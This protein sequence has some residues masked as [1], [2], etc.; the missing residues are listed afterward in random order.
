MK[1]IENFDISV[2]KEE[3]ILMLGGDLNNAERALKIIDAN[4]DAYNEALEL[5]KPRAIYDVIEI[6][7]IEGNRLY[8]DSE[9]FFESKLI[10]RLMSGTKYLAICV[11]T[12]GIDLENKVEEYMK[13][14]QHVK[15]LIMDG[16]GTVVLEKAGLQIREILKEEATMRNLDFSA[17]LSPGQ[18]G[19]DVS[20]QRKIFKRLDASRIGVSLR[21]S[22]LMIPRKS[23]S[24]AMGIG[25]GVKHDKRSCDFCHLKN[26][27]PSRMLYDY[28]DQKNK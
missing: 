3:L 19:W 16:V 14:G 18:V 21:P 23:L 11:I 13:Q 10:P 2:D 28:Q 12:V 27:C 17:A 4:L 6:D 26:S 22:S 20:D 24:L 1:I 8:L 15:G 9:E 5:V 25:D 7:R